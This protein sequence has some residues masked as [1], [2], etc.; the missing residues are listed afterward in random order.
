MF[1]LFIQVPYLKI[2]D[3]KIKVERI[4]NEKSGKIQLYEYGKRNLVG[5]QYTYMEVAFSKSKWTSS[6]TWKCFLVKEVINK[7]FLGHLI[8][9]KVSMA[10]ESFKMKFA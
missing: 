5:I 7:I 4:C 2:A 1:K 10:F 6:S 9:L 8:N 3:R